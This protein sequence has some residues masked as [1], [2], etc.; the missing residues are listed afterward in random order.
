MKTTM[1]ILAAVY[2]LLVSCSS[3]KHVSAKYSDDVYS[4][5][6]VSY[7]ATTNESSSNYYSDAPIT[8]SQEN[9]EVYTEK[10]VE[11]DDKGNTYVTNNYY[12]YDPDDYY[13]YEYT[14]RIRRFHNTYIG[15]GYYDSYYTN[16]Y[17]YTYDPF[18]WGV[19][20]Y[21]GFR[22]WPFYF[23]YYYPAY[24]AV[25]FYYPWYYDPWWGWH[26]YYYYTGYYGYGYWSGYHHG[27]WHGYWDGYWHGYYNGNYAY[28]YYYNS[29]DGVFYGHRGDG[30]YSGSRVNG[31]YN[32]FIQNYQSSR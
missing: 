1:I 3:A 26:P 11:T 30:S 32:S 5:S 9:K 6:S 18:D 31:N 8:Q 21:F 12:S 16:L 25:G 13:D 28:N 23:Y 24:Y 19:S 29:Y 22:W 14:S 10:S 17:W 2:L 4:T 27:Y 20:I 15:C 7:N